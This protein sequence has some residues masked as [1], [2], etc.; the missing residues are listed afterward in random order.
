MERGYDTERCYGH[1]DWT[2]GSGTDIRTDPRDFA[3]LS[4]LIS[5]KMRVGQVSR[6]VKGR[7]LLG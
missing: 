6:K 4:K 1:G 7:R 5:G 2:G 3:L